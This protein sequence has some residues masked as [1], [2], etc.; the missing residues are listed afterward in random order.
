MEKN[1]IGRVIGLYKQN[2]II[3][4]GKS[5]LRCISKGKKNEAV[6][7]D[8]VN[9]NYK[10]DSYYIITEI[11]QRNNL[12]LRSD[13]TKTR[14]IA[15]NIDNVILLVAAEPDFSV[16]LI[17]KIIIEAVRCN[18]KITIVL[19]KR[20]LS[21]SIKTAKEKL[22]FTEIL[23]IPL[24]EISAKYPSSEEKSILDILKGKVTLITGPSGMGKSTLVNLLVP[25]ACAATREYS[26]FLNTGKHTTSYTKLYKLTLENSYIIDSPGFKDFGLNHLSF[27]DIVKPFL[28]FRD[29]NNKCRFYNCTHCHEPGCKIIESKT[30]G[31]IDEKMYSLYKK[32][33]GKYILTHGN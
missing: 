13:I 33:M 25:E 12:F 2:Y 14:K 21:R 5:V 11:I 15:A 16:E 22:Y 8:F 6:V 3:A 32:I 28:E 24:L 9:V 29:L 20:D 23:G 10:S 7:G 30:N 18:T 4:H 19:N 1:I 31:T 27:N 26:K 17:L